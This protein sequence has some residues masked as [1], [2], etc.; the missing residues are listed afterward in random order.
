MDLSALSA[1]PPRVL[2][3]RSQR[4]GIF[5]VEELD[6]DFGAAGQ[7]TYERLR[8]GPGAVMALPY[9]GTHFYLVSEYACG[10]ERFELGLVKGKIDAGESPQQACLR[11]LSEEIGLTAGKLTPLKSEMTVAPG[12]M[13]LKMFP[14]LCTDLSYRHLDSGDEL[15]PPQVIKV[16]PKEAQELIFDPHSPLQESRTIAC[17]CLGLRAALADR[18]G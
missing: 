10:F 13:S 3:R 14:F 5:T 9:D 4:L 18:G 1:T 7:A 12:L 15:L 2:A 17:L 6:L 16:T 8:G 11:E